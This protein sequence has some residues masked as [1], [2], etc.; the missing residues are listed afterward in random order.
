MQSYCLRH[1]T[2]TVS[3]AVTGPQITVLSFP[4]DL[5]SFRGTDISVHAEHMALPDNVNIKY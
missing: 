5:Q 3:Y 2:N 4:G 1:W